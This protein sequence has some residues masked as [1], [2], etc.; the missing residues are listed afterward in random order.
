[1]GS[2]EMEK[3]AKEAEDTP[4]ESKPSSSPLHVGR[5]VEKLKALQTLVPNSNKVCM[6]DATD[7][8]SMLDE[9]IE[10]LKQLQLK[11]QSK[12]VLISPVT[13]LPYIQICDGSLSGKN[14]NDEEDLGEVP[15]V[16]EYNTKYFLV[17]DVELVYVIEALD[18]SKY[19][20]DSDGADV[21]RRC[22]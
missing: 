20:K 18:E 6:I 3:S 8:A 21:N 10:Y 5:S 1:M 19:Q 13:R 17:D 4:K 12:F 14:N 11:V 7:K 9:A 15:D 2:S 16:Y 22:L